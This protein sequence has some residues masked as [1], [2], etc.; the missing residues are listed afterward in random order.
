MS[1]VVESCEIDL[2]SP[3]SSLATCEMSPPGCVMLSYCDC[4]SVFAATICERIEEIASVSAPAFCTSD[5]L[6]AWLDGSVLTVDQAVKKSESFWLTPLS[7]GSESESS[8][9]FER[10]GAGGLLL[11]ARVL[12]AVLRVQEVVA[13]PACSR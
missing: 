5:C 12:A 9:V 1:P 4:A 10:A 13:N 11:Q 6:A 2:F 3:A 8:A 7:P